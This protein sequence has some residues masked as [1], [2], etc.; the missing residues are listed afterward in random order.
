MAKAVWR[1]ILNSITTT[2]F[3]TILGMPLADAAA[4]ILLF[5][6]FLWLQEEVIESIRG[7]RE[8]RDRSTRTTS[9]GRRKSA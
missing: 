6:W 5:W 2:V 7:R 4:V 3:L 8:A 9:R 1:L